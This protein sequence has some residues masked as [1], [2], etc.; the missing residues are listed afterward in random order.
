MTLMYLQ[1]NYLHL[2]KQQIEV[3]L[4]RRDIV[5][6]PSHITAERQE[7]SQ[8]PIL[9]CSKEPQFSNEM[10]TARIVGKS[11]TPPDIIPIPKAGPRQNRI[12]KRGK[13]MILTATPNLNDLKTSSTTKNVKP[14][15]ARRKLLL[16][17]NLRSKKPKKVGDSSSS[18]AWK[19]ATWNFILN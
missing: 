9:G 6:S 16:N 15:A 13:T 3:P 7:G 4:N 12:Q 19:I 17:E 14:S 5:E 1:K 8:S 10:T 11:Y 2:L 18:D